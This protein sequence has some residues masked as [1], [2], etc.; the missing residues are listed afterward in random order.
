MLR[1]EDSLFLGEI[2]KPSGRSSDLNG[3]PAT[4]SNGATCADRSSGTRRTTSRSPP[5]GPMVTSVRPCWGGPRR[6][7]PF[8]RADY[9]KS[10][11]P[12]TF[13]PAPTL[14][15]I[16][17]YITAP[18][19]SVLA[20]CVNI[21]QHP[22]QAELGF[23]MD[24]HCKARPRGS[25]GCRSQVVSDSWSRE[26]TQSQQGRQIYSHAA[27]LISLIRAASLAPFTQGPL[28]SP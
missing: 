2:I 13:S 17:T 16:V 19:H 3:A 12:P 23:S 25:L 28:S 1:R 4:S 10:K 7:R 24:P 15:S 9:P 14:I 27:P 6:Q 11:I 20:F 8:E 5:S 21:N 26:L 22:V 18:L